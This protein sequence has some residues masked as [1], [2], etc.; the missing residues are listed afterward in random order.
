MSL[1]LLILAFSLVCAVGAS[2]A[3]QGPHVPGKLRHECKAACGK[4]C[5]AVA[6]DPTDHY[7][8]RGC[9]KF[10]VPRCLDALSQGEPLTCG[11]NRPTC[12][13]A[14]DC[15]DGFCFNLSDRYLTACVDTGV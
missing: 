9:R 12:A 3:T 4:Y 14:A 5:R 13:S 2:Y 10:S 8:L 7:W 11:G 15:P 1:R 6:L